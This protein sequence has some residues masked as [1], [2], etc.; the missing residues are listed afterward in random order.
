MAVPWRFPRPRSRRR[1]F[2]SQTFAG[3]VDRFYVNAPPYDVP[4]NTLTVQPITYGLGNESI[5]DAIHPG[6]PYK[7]GGELYHYRVREQFMPVDFSSISVYPYLDSSGTIV[8]RRPPSTFLDWAWLGSPTTFNPAHQY[9]A[10]AWNRFKPGKPVIDLGVTIAEFKQ[11]PQL[12]LKRF[13]SVKHIANNNLA[14]QFGWAP[15]LA[16]ARKMA[17]LQTTVAA[18]LAQLRRDNGKGV[19]RRGVLV[20]EVQT[21]QEIVCDGVNSA[22]SEV[23]QYGYNHNNMGAAVPFTYTEWLESHKVWFSARFRYWIPDIG[24]QQWEARAIKTLMGLDITPSLAWEIMPWSWLVDWFSNV[25]DVVS[26][27]TENAAENLVADYAFIM[28]ERKLSQRTYSRFTLAK[29]W[30]G[31]QPAFSMHSLEQ[32]EQYRDR[33]HPYGFSADWS[34]LSASQLSILGSLGITKFPRR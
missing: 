10:T 20:N 33:A 2:G 26:N 6:P 22:N 25:G 30:G 29:R 5:H 32:I 3:R 13:D 31:I 16:D 15:L 28:R 9:G 27:M 14:V 4:H 1:N 18:K 7:T 21:G 11:I 23:Y 12:L 19:R 8:T 34:S 24:T 17:T